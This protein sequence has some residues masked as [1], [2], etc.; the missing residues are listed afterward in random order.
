MKELVCYTFVAMK[1]WTFF[2]SITL[3]TLI[4]FNTLRVPF[5]YLYYQLDP[6]NF[7]E[8]LC[9]NK[10]KPELQCNGKCHLKKVSQSAEDDKTT[11][12][13]S[14]FELL[15]FHQPLTDFK[16]VPSITFQKKNYY[17]YV[18][19]YQFKYKLSCFHPPQV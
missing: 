15:L 3:S 14:N 1:N 7:I 8:N 12:N 4:M 6:V 2:F 5:T 10:D 17:T 13:T 9:V 19:L 18:N 11:T 16:L